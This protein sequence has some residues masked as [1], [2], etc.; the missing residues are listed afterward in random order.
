VPQL[1]PGAPDQGAGE[2]ARIDRRLAVQSADLD[3][4]GVVP[5]LRQTVAQ[6]ELGG[7]WIRRDVLDGL[8]WDDLPWCWKTFSLS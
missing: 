8:R 3:A 5:F 2:L 7:S 1:H 4:A 6:P